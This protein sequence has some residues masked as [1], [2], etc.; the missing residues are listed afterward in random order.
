MA[1]PCRRQPHGFDQ[2]PDRTRASVDLPITPKAKVAKLHA[3]SLSQTINMRDI[4]NFSH[5]PQQNQNWSSQTMKN[6]GISRCI[7]LRG[8][9]WK[10]GT[11]RRAERSCH[12]T[13][14]PRGLIL[15]DP[16]AVLPIALHR[17]RHGTY[18]PYLSSTLL[19]TAIRCGEV[20]CDAVSV[21]W[22]PPARAAQAYISRLLGRTGYESECH[23]KLRAVGVVFLTAFARGAVIEAERPHYGNGRCV[24][25]DLVARRE[26]N[27][28][29]T[30]EVGAVEGDSILAQLLAYRAA[31]YV[32][33]I[34][35]AGSRD[36]SANG[37][38]F[39]LQTT[40]VLV[41]PSGTD[42]RN[43]WV[44]LTKD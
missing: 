24:R 9:T 38:A 41:S 6:V 27:L 1:R 4:E 16:T 10:A 21:T 17:T 35:F 19:S 32:V 7:P 25:S 29:A 37:Y 20:T 8:G 12:A 30:V 3:R 28:I 39:R 15:D 14:V 33:V 13:F 18:R 44:L 2:K 26:R 5:L 11:D 42:L 31:P 34:P 43:S 40:P 36:R 23:R 22:I